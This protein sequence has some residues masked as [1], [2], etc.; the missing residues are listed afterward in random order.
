MN[1]TEK[2]AFVLR[3]AEMDLDALREGDRLNTLDDVVAFLAWPP[4]SVAG[5]WLAKNLNLELVKELQGDARFVLKRLAVDLGLFDEKGEVVPHYIQAITRL[6]HS[7]LEVWTQ[8]GRHRIIVPIKEGNLALDVTQP[9]SLQVQ[10]INSVDIRTAFRVALAAV[11]AAVG[12]PALRICPAPDCGKLFVAE[13]G[14]RQFCSDRCKAREMMRRYRET[15]REEEKE[16][17]H[18]HYARK[19][20]KELGPNVKIERRPRTQKVKEV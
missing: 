7:G 5:G 2:L 12:V 1:D 17:S 16:R 8:G 3:L 6:S 18:K 19:K 9:G 14:K 13:H 11:L 15:H 10:I 20:K 4:A